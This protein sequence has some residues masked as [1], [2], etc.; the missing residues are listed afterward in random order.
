[1]TLRLSFNPKLKIKLNM[2][3]FE[4]LKKIIQTLNAHI[5]KNNKNTKDLIFLEDLIVSEFLDEKIID[6][7]ATFNFYLNVSYHVLVASKDAMDRFNLNF[8]FC[9]YFC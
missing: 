1:M 9:K 8:Q 6:L 7:D 2:D 3:V 5:L 4:N